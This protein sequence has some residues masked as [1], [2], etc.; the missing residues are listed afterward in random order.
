LFEAVKKS[1]YGDAVRRFDSTESIVMDMVDCAI[2]GGNLF[3]TVDILKQ[4]TLQD[5][6]DRLRGLK[7]ESAVLSLI[8]PKQGKD[9]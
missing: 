6:V 2:G 4:I 8:L 3:D 7:K 9:V 5:I 1:A